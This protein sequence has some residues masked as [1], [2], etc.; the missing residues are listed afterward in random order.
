[1]HF[2]S[3]GP[4]VLFSTKFP[5]STFLALFVHRSVDTELVA[6]AVRSEKCISRA[7]SFRRLE[8]RSGC[9]G[10]TDSNSR[11]QR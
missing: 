10:P 7:K 3:A 5:T 11:S 4:E 9:A 6:P 2:Q 8:A 1:M